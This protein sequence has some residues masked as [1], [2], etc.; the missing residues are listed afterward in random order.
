VN[1]WDSK[2]EPTV[3]AQSNNFAVTSVTLITTVST[4]ADD[5][6]NARVSIYLPETPLFGSIGRGYRVVAILTCCHVWIDLV[7]TATFGREHVGHQVGANC[8][9]LIKRFLPKL[10]ILNVTRTPPFAKAAAIPLL[11]NHALCLSQC[12]F[13]SSAF[14]G[15]VQGCWSWPTSLY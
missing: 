5:Q 15:F 1:A 9:I 4:L 6:S 11:A 14:V 2:H 8:Q 12:S 10:E 7:K 13:Y 3:T